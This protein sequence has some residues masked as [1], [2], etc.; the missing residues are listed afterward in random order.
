MREGTQ[1]IKALS[2]LIFLIETLDLDFAFIIL[3]AFKIIGF[4]PSDLYLG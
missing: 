1:S 2:R 3:P 4:K